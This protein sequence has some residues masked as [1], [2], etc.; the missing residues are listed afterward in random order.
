MVALLA[1]IAISATQDCKWKCQK[2]Q[3]LH[4]CKVFISNS[5]PF[6]INCIMAQV[7]WKCCQC[8][9][10]NLTICN[11]NADSTYKRH[12]T[13]FWCQCPFCIHR[14]CN[15]CGLKVLGVWIEC[16]LTC[17]HVIGSCAS[18]C[19]CLSW[20]KQTFLCFLHTTRPI[21]FQKTSKSTKINHWLNSFEVNV[22]SAFSYRYFYI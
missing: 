10:T 11:P 5:L 7:L 19:Y 4:Y 6:W 1:H 3:Q 18:F 13:G 2:Y 16:L 22:P 9:E 8:N 14:L 20:T 21:N 15:S 17:H 12:G